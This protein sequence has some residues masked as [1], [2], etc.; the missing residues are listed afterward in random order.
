MSPAVQAIL[1]Q[2]NVNTLAIAAIAGGKY[3]QVHNDLSNSGTTNAAGGTLETLKTFTV[4]FASYPLVDGETV[5]FTSRFTIAANARDHSVGYQL[6][7]GIV[8]DVVLVAFPANAGIAQTVEVHVEIERINVASARITQKFLWSTSGTNAQEIYYLSEIEAV[9][10][11][12]N[13][14]LRAV[15]QNN[16]LPYTDDDVV[17]HQLKVIKIDNA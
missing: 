10:F 9:D 2:V 1:A 15:G 5:K 16:T 3:F 4:L 7:Q 14:D 8:K 11:T 13:F 12:A 17:C 6:F